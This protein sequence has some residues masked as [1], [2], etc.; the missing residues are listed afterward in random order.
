MAAGRGL[1]HSTDGGSTFT[2]FDTIANVGPFSFGK[3]APGQTYPA[4]FASGRV[5]NVTG[6]FRSD[7]A[8]HTWV[9]VNDD[10]HQFGGSP[11]VLCGDPRVFGRVYLG[12]NGRGIQMGQPN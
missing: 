7:D 5:G 10:D 2:A 11:T 12:F 9:R 3:A 1:V 8:A 6:V 4:L